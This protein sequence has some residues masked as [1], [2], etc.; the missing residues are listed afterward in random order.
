MVAY[1]RHYPT[2]WVADYGK[3]ENPSGYMMTPAIF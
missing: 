2:S 3:T 1:S